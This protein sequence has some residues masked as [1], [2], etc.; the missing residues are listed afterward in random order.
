MQFDSNINQKGGGSGFGLYIAKGLA[1]LH[2][3]ASVK[4]DSAG[5][6]MGS[7]FSIRL[8]F[9]HDDVSTAVQEQRSS[10]LSA[11][12]MESSSE[13]LVVLVAD[14]SYSN[15]KML[16]SMLER[17]GHTVVE[18][19]DGLE[20]V[21]EVMRSMQNKDSRSSLQFDCILMDSNMPKLTGLE[22]VCEL[23]KIGYRGQVIGVTGDDYD[24][25]AFLNE[26]AAQALLK[27][28]RKQSLVDALRLVSSRLECGSKVVNGE[29]LHSMNLSMGCPSS[30]SASRHGSIITQ[31]DTVKEESISTN[32]QRRNNGR[33][34]PITST[35]ITRQR[36]H[37]MSDMNT[38]STDTVSTNNTY[39]TTTRRRR[40]SITDISSS[41]SHGSESELE[42]LSSTATVTAEVS[43]THSPK[44]N[45]TMGMNAFS[46]T[47]AAMPCTR[48]N[49]AVSGVTK[50]NN[51]T[52]FVHTIR[53]TAKT[54][55]LYDM[56]GHDDHHHQQQ[57]QKK[58]D[59]LFAHLYSN[60]E[61][62]SDLDYLL[63]FTNPKYLNKQTQLEFFE[64]DMFSEPF[65]IKA[66]VVFF[67]F[68]VVVLLF[69][70]LLILISQP[71]RGFVF[72]LPFGLLSIFAML[73]V[74][75][76]FNRAVFFASKHYNFYDLAR[77]RTSWTFSNVQSFEN[78][79][80]ISKSMMVSLVVI[81]RFLE[82]PCPSHASWLQQ[83]SCNSMA[84]ANFLPVEALV[85]LLVCPMIHI[86]II[87]GPEAWLLFPVVIMVMMTLNIALRLVECRYME[88]YVSLNLFVILS[89]TVMY[90]LMSSRRRLFIKEKT[91]LLNEKEA[92]LIKN[93]QNKKLVLQLS[94]S[95]HDM[96][97]PC[98]AIGMLVE[99]QKAELMNIRDGNKA[100]F[101]QFLS[102]NKQIN[103][104]IALM[105]MSVNRALVS[106]THSH[107]SLYC[108]SY[109]ILS[110]IHTDS[111]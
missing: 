110:L 15:R 104:S 54:K 47:N 82:G 68:S 84:R 55:E 71:Q 41:V 96:R 98:M 49:A 12:N 72:W 103:S 57:Q 66:M 76:G 105:N 106:R 26:G 17:L 65:D 101:N 6:G 85:A 56:D 93:E 77:F 52:N 97:S 21:G 108:L 42:S 39:T 13:R 95:A 5:R 20:A 73:T 27:P 50:N 53:N 37:A 59:S 18:A 87:R 44:E 48:T 34:T 102:L 79:Y 1:E 8:P 109:H 78:L 35:I 30:R 38:V 61:P 24:R 22:A 75:V 69:L 32:K 43:H 14:D 91:R 62:K 33:P 74:I 89:Y 83:Q 25:E 40:R 11:F 60:D 58:K 10:K 90:G 36:K 16:G 86:A 111:S 99:Q 2:D 80:F 28:L 88:T 64:F 45:S 19:E 3:G 9:L 81:L 70:P 107:S 29:S 63:R 46:S 23:K 100:S 94:N 51:V 92:L 7:V 67:T 4:G 31:A